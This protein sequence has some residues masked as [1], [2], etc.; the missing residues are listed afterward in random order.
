MLWWIVIILAIACIGWLLAHTRSPV[1]W[2]LSLVAA[3]LMIPILVLWLLLYTETGLAL[4]K[5]QLVHLQRFGIHIEGVSGR[6]AGPL[7][8]ERFELDHPRVH[9]VSHDIVVRPRLRELIIQTIG[10]RTV[11]ARDTLVEIRDAPPEPPPTKPL[12]FLPQFMRIDIKDAQLTGVRYVHMDGTAVDAD[13][14]RGEVTLTAR[15]IRVPRF[16]ARGEWFELDG[17]LRLT[18]QRPLGIELATRGKLAYRGIE[19]TV[20]GGLDGTIDALGMRA[21]IAAPTRADAKGTFT[22]IDDRWRIEGKVSSPEFSLAPWI[23]RPPFSMR[24]VAMDVV[25]EPGL[26]IQANGTLIVP[27]VDDRPLTLD[28]RGGYA[29]RTIRIERADLT[30]AD[31]PARLRASGS[32]A[33]QSEARPQV[34]ARFVWTDM[35]WPLRGDPLVASASGSGTLRGALPYEFTVDTRVTG[36]GIP[37]AAGTA[38]GTISNSD[39]TLAAFDVEMLGGRVSGTGKLAFTTPNA[40]SFNTTIDGIDP[41]GIDER[42][43][44]WVSGRIAANGTGLDRKARFAA[45]VS[46][47]RGRLRDQRLRGNGAIERTA[48][49]WKVR[50]AR[51]DYGRAQLTLDGE[52]GEEVHARWNISAPSLERLL[53]DAQGSLE[54]S[55]SAHGPIESPHVIVAARGER[56]GYLGW[57]AQTLTVNGDV[58]LGGERR[59]QLSIDAQQIGKASPWLTHIRITG[60]GTAADHRLAVDVLGSAASARDVPPHAQFAMT[61]RYA[62]GAWSATIASSEI[63]T[64]EDD[65]RL[66]LAEPGML[67]VAQH[68][69]VLEPLCFA[70]GNGRL[71]AEGTWERGNA[72]NAMLSGYELPLAAFLPPA[73]RDAQFAGRIEGRVRLFGSRDTVWQGD[74]GMRIIDAAVIYRPPFGEPEV[75]NLGTGGL[76]ARATAERIEFS[77]GVQAFTD[78]FLFANANIDRSISRALMDSPLIG[79]FRAR[80]ADANILPLFFPEIDNAAGLLTAQGN[81]RGTLAQPQIEGRIELTNGEFDSYR[82]NLA[83]RDL[84][85]IAN[86]Q[87]NGLDFRGT[88]RAGDGTLDVTGTF[89]WRNGI[90]RGQL[91]LRGQNLLV[92]DLPEYRVIASPDLQFAI[93]GRYISA[94][95]TVEIPSA[96]VQPVD[97]TGA[98][99]ISDDA[100]YVGEHPAERDGRYIVSSDIRINMGDD[101]RVESFGLQGRIR[102]GVSTTVRTGETPIGRGELSVVEGRY[103]A[104]GQKLE[105][106]RGQLLFEASPLADPGLDIEA[107]RKIE[108]VIVGLNVRG[109][110]QQP[111]LSFFSEP[112]MPQTQ[113]IS[114]LLVGKPVDAMGTSDAAAVGSATDA[115]AVQG[116]GLLASQIGRRLGLEEVGVESTTDR[117]GEVNQQLVLG[118]FLSPRLF[119]SYGI[120]LTESINTLKLRYTISDRWVLKTEA[121][122]NQSA[123]IEFNVER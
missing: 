113:I 37:N 16:A 114:Y 53:P 99:Q 85:L 3:I 33:L 25:L 68:R 92:S 80:A 55:G 52:L 61:G 29:D 1:K 70:I 57:H 24:A 104:Y 66:A 30:L 62:D 106:T 117:D 38:S 27:E 21:S 7:Y 18:A 86:L 39:L 32:V 112:S 56:I 58:D 17:E 73:G 22:R 69:A 54:F 47:L 71:C 42:F 75:L 64:G 103:E 121:G 63:T 50:E 110:L 108:S 90:S 100:R 74:A 19:Y 34:D 93:D 116:G 95:G 35:Q 12:R 40:W 119:V 9:V 28:A 6:L 78:T 122:E 14:V 109:T 105:I 72:W 79:D 77:F 67:A 23:E 10:V 84:H 44:G 48:R 120:S 4:A 49:S 101:V 59:S 26:L 88:G 2:I 98:V 76:G 20:D 81:V 91:Q 97:L 118:K 43:P 115:L 60:E 5:N 8:V 36:P 83:L 45:T 87:G 111:R 65:Q 15:H 11:T 89:A 46:D 94:S 96:R 123:D 13:S 31:S 82:V 107:R 51:V 41:A 102:G